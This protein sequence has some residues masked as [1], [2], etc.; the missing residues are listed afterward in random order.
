MCDPFFEFEVIFF[1]D[2]VVT[3]RTWDRFISIYDLIRANSTVRIRFTS[4]AS[5]RNVIS[6]GT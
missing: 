1:V 2:I 5:D 4:Y 3:G 6:Y